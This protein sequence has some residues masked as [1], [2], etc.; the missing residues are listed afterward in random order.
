MNYRD[1]KYVEKHLSTYFDEKLGEDVE[2]FCNIK[3][4]EGIILSTQILD[5]SCFN[6]WTSKPLVLDYTFWRWSRF[7]GS[8]PVETDECYDYRLTSPTK[9]YKE[10]IKKVNVELKWITENNNNHNCRSFT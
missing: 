9:S 3:Y 7:F 5:K 10:L 4:H 6:A 1:P 2:L 8:R